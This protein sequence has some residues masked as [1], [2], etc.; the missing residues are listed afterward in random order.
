MRPGLGLLTSL[1]RCSQ[2][3]QDPSLLSG[4]F[5]SSPAPLGFGP[6]LPLW[7]LCSSSLFFPG[8]RGPSLAAQA[9]LQV[10][11]LAFF[12]ACSGLSLGLVHWKKL[13]QRKEQLLLWPPSF[14]PS[15]LAILALSAKLGPNSLLLLSSSSSSC[16]SWALLC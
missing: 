4:L 11:T 5:A 6:S 10:Q 12:Q 7:L 1:W 14:K 15:F 16:A 13:H 3:C 8:R 9:F 2:A